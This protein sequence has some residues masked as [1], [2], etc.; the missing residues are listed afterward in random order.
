[1]LLKKYNSEFDIFQEYLNAVLQHAKEFKEFHRTVSSKIAKL[2]K[3][4]MMHHM[5]T[6]KEQ[7]KEQERLEKERLRRLM[8]SYRL[9]EWIPLQ[10]RPL[11]QVYFNF[12]AS[13]GV[14]RKNIASSSRYF[15]YR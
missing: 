5:N 9:R 2:N 11:C 4:V 15:P 13:R 14:D 6:E 7:K 1:M 8:V 12:L 10:E 3:A